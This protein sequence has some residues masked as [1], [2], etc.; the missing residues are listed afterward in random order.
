[1]NFFFDLV[2]DSS[3]ALVVNCSSILVVRPAHSADLRSR[4]HGVVMHQLL[5]TFLLLSVL[6]HFHNNYVLSCL[7]FCHQGQEL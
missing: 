4:Q 3:N 1:M 2:P 6:I 7:K 5:F